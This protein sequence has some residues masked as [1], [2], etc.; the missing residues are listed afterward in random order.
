[1]KGIL[2]VLLSLAKLEILHFNLIFTSTFGTYSLGL[3]V[4]FGHASFVS[5]NT[6]G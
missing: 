1:M 3:N 5:L 6:V 4:Q 2:I